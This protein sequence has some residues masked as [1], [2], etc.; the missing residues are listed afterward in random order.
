MDEATGLEPPESARLP[1]WQAGNVRSPSRH[2]VPRPS[3]PFSSFPARSKERL[4][5]PGETHRA[6]FH[7]DN[8]AD[9]AIEIETPSAA[10]PFFNPIVRLLNSC[11]RGGGDEYLRREGR[12]QRSDD[13]IG[14][15]QD[16]RAAS[17]SR[18]LHVRDPR[19]HGRSRRPD[20]QYRVQVRPQVPMSAR[21]GS[22]RT[23]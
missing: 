7:L 10:P 15:I 8:P 13:Q 6:R 14:A 21:C 20:F 16:D 19:R 5:S 2:T 12:V 23:T 1:W 11:G 22:I 9:L 17:G 4:L 3:R 18:R